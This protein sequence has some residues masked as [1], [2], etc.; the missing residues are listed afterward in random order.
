MLAVVTTSQLELRNGVVGEWQYGG[1]YVYVE[2]D[3]AVYVD[4]GEAYVEV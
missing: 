3:G 4:D 2:D 1:A